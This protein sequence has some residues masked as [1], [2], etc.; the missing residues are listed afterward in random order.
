MLIYSFSPGIVIPLTTF[1]ERIAFNMRQTHQP[2]KT[3]SPLTIMAILII[4]ALYPL[5][6]SYGSTVDLT[7]LSLEEL[8]NI[9][10]TSVG[11]KEQKLSDSAA[12]IF[13]ITNEEIRR[14][15][16]TSI[17]DA[18]RMVPGMNVARIDANKWAVNSRAF[19]GRFSAQLLVMIDGRSVY[20]PT[21]SGVYW[22]VND[23]LLED[24]DRIE[25]IRGPGATLWGA[26]AVN[27]VINIITKSAKDTQGGFASAGTGTA[28]TAMAGVRYG[29]AAGS[30]THL[31]I[32]AK[33]DQRDEFESVS[34]QDAN[35]DWGV[36]RAGFRMDSNMTDRDSMTLQ[37]DL[38]SGDIHQNLYLADLTASPTFMNTFAVETSV[39]GGNLLSR[40][41]RTLQSNSD[42]TLQVYYDTS[43]RTEDFINETRH[44]IDIDFQH[45]FTARDVHDI[46][47]GL[48]YRFSQDDFSDPDTV[49]TNVADIYPDS[50]T[51]HLY[52]G[53]IQD[54]ISFLDNRLHLTLGTKF[55]HNDYSGFEVQP[56]VRVMWAP[57]PSHRL[58]GAVS[59]AIRTPSRGESSAV[60]TYLAFNSGAIGSPFP[61]GLPVKVDLIGNDDFEPEEL[62]AYELGYR[63]IPGSRFSLDATMFCHDYDQLRTGRLVFD[64]VSL[65]QNLILENNSSGYVYGAELAMSYRFTDNF[66]MDLAYAFTDDDLEEQRTDSIVNHQV[67]LRNSLNLSQDVMLDVWLRYVDDIVVADLLSSTG[68]SQVDDYLTMDIRLSWKMM[69]GLELS[70]V[71]QNLLQDSHLEFIPEGF[72]L[73]VEVPRS[74]YAMINYRF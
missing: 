34:G 28:E 14:S 43:E 29:W 11:K 27:G 66:K 4:F 48:R 52:S 61:A 6:S 1:V 69:K 30:D 47:W 51:D 63:F 21:F 16:A 62:I 5:S 40:W 68:W 19:N 50:Q 44:N 3:S 67:S 13:V 60:V 25:V 64:P 38:Y 35:D 74:V 42:L 41:K 2:C 56:S 72:N 71:G 10:V 8:M 23:L 54:D 7:E 37:G 17:P 39:S 32:Y 45:R 58:W 15:G 49:N 26:N 22:E 65:K 24:V 18:L 53:F 55:E 20:T 59:R 73:P 46:I 70:L 57:N 33:H 31:R 9:K 12:A 36:T